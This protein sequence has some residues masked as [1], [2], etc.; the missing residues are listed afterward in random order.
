MLA[1]S[2]EQ[3]SP[4]HAQSIRPL[5]AVACAQPPAMKLGTLK[6]G[7]RDG[8]LVLVSR[9]LRRA[10]KIPD[11]APTLQAALDG[12]AQ[13][14]PRLR[15]A[16]EPFDAM[17]AA[18]DLP[19]DARQFESPLPRAYQWIDGSSYINHLEL[20]R[21]ARAAPMPPEFWTDPPMYQGGSQAFLGPCDAIPCLNEDYG[22]DLEAEIAIITDDVPMQVDEE[23]AREHIKLIMLANDISLRNL[24]PS[25]LAKGFGYFQSKPASS[26]SPVAVTPD[27]LDDAWD[28]GK[29][30]LPVA[31]FINDKLLGR[32]DAGMDMQFEFPRLVA[33]AARTR[34]L[35]AGT[36]IG[37]GTVSNTDRSVGSACIVE[38]RMLEMIATGRGTTPYL[39]NGDRLRIE[40]VD[41]RG[42][43]IFGAIEQTV[44]PF[45][46]AGPRS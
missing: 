3:N 28:G 41:Y 43:S 40:I 25:E 9:D 23:S 6:D 26:F 37:S 34:K 27:E 35:G 38:R 44:V 13:V 1:R 30:C 31:V 8:C 20:V 7:S 33:H 19:F 15:A 22:M 46:G 5:R 32:P 18:T 2:V 45:L 29:L 24:I 39:R 42:K 17:P 4:A 12:W 16:Y 14:E 11:L 21:K 36:I 10:R